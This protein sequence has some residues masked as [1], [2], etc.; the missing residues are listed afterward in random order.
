MTSVDFG[1]R[2]IKAAREQ[3]SRGTRGPHDRRKW[4]LGAK[5]CS[6]EGFNVSAH[7]LRIINNQA[8]LI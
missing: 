8:D 1:D 7:I 2:F 5:G 4:G 3:G 6:G